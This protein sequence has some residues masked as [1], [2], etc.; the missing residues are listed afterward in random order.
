MCSM[1]SAWQECQLLKAFGGALDPVKS[2]EHAESAERGTVTA[3]EGE[4]LVS[5]LFPL[6][7]FLLSRR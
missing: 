4:H 5:Y 7:F 3:W 1:V 6:S 2:E